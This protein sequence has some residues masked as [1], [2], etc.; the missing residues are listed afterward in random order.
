MLRKV[1]KWA[2][3]GLGVLFLLV[4]VLFVIHKLNQPSDTERVERVLRYAATSGDPSVCDDF[5]TEAYL[6]QTT[7]YPAPFA[8]SACSQAI[9]GEDQADRT[10]IKRLEVDGDTAVARVYN[11]GGV[12]DQVEATIRLDKVEGQWRLAH[13]IAINDFNRDAYA[14]ASRDFYLAE[15]WPPAA[16][17]CVGARIRALPDAVIKARLLEGK[18]QPLTKIAVACGRAEVE[19]DLLETVARAK[20]SSP[21]RAVSCVR[22]RLRGDGEEDLASLSSDV[23]AYGRLILA[24]DPKAPFDSMRSELL[25]HEYL[26]PAAADCVIRAARELS[27]EEAFR[28][29]FEDDR[30][31]ELIDGCRQSAAAG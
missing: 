15:G 30:Y 1:V 20:L 7:G 19:R 23:P 28:L 2:L 29:A 10:R 22:R 24:C 27:R 8:D 25:A 31:G 16:A 18:T 12:T 9:A 17:R 11:E 26:E 21:A 13:V 3:R 5:N 4:V 6:E 14:G